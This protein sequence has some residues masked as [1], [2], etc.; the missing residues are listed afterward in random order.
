ME[1]AV[2][3]R[4]RIFIMMA[5]LPLLCLYASI[6]EEIIVLF[7]TDAIQLPAGQDTT[8]LDDIVAPQKV[9]DYMWEFGTERIIRAIPNFNRADT[10]RVTE[11]GWEARLPDWSNLY[12]IDVRGDRDSA[13]V[14]LE[15]LDEVI[16]AEK[17]EKAEPLYV[18]PPNDTWFFKQWALNDPAGIIGIDVMRAWDLSCGSNSIVI[19]QKWGQIFTLYIRL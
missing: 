8:M 14:E 1:A 6:D 2:K 7:K 9:I 10:L 18:E 11:D 19:V 5:M 12:V 16:Y 4:Q 15:T 17:N 3:V 13:I